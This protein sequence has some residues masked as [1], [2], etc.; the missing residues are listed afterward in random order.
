M[1]LLYYDRS[2]NHLQDSQVTDITLSDLRKKIDLKKEELNK[3]ERAL[4]ALEGLAGMTLEPES[5]PA[6]P[7]LSDS[8]RIDL[9]EIK[10]PNK[11][12][13]E[14][15][16]LV[17]QVRKLIPR[18]ENQEFTVSHVHQILLTTDRAKH[19]KHLRNRVSVAFKK[20]VE[21]NCI[22][23]SKRGKGSDPHMYKAVGIDTSDANSEDFKL[24]PADTGPISSTRVIAAH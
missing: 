22:A 6:K 14:K 3:L 17:D 15:E 18:F 11:V 1:P 21:E 7:V 23:V 10:L 16:T 24:G 4:E 13:S 2:S 5:E 20:L 12:K 19:G 8:G 9:N